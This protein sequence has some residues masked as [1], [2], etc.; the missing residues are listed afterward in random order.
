MLRLSKFQFHISKDQC[1]EFVQCSLD[2]YIY[3]YVFI[4][5]LI[6]CEYIYIVRNSPQIRYRWEK[7]IHC[8]KGIRSKTKCKTKK[9]KF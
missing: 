5:I 7:Q 1:T 6:L 9:P 4:L 2:I 3:V 8:V